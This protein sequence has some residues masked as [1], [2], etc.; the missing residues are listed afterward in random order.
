[1]FEDSMQSSVI[2]PKAGSLRNGMCFRRPEAE[3]RISGGGSS[4]WRTP[5]SHDW[6]GGITGRDGSTR[7]QADYFLPDQVNA[8]MWP[9]PAA[10]EGF[11]RRRRDVAKRRTDG[12]QTAVKMWPTPNVRDHH[13]Q[14][15]GHDPKAQSSRLPLAVRRY[16][17]PTRA[18][19]EGGP[20][21]NGREGGENLRTAHGG[22]LNPTWVEWLMNW[23]LG[24]TEI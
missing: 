7:N 9:T 5:R 2:W 12:L 3:R 10:A 16:P 1:L 13:A 21:T 17:T 18:D 6:K 14:G 4:F 23:P 22:Q 8:R 24:W 19:G 11:G 20:G 15:A